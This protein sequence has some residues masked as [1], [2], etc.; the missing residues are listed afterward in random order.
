MTMKAH[1]QFYL[2]KLTVPRAIQALL[3]SLILA[4]A[5]LSHNSVVYACPAGCGGG[6]GGG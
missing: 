2:L 1:I 4:L 6:C 5:L 3:V